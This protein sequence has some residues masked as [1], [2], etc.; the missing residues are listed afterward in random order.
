VQVAYCWGM[1]GKE[2]SGSWALAWVDLKGCWLAPAGLKLS[3]DKGM[4][5]L[6]ERPRMVA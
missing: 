1:G 5:L 3:M 4:W 2:L 6:L